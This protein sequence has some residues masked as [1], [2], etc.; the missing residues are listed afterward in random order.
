MDYESVVAASFQASP[1]DAVSA[2]TV[3]ASP[4]RRLRDAIEPIAMHSVW[5]RATN[6]R[7]AEMDLDFLT[8]YVWGRAAAL[9]EPDAGVVVA[10]F[11]VFEPGL[12]RDAYEQGRR[13]CPRDRLLAARTD[14]TVASLLETLEGADV[15]S[16]ADILERAVSVADGTGRPLFSGLAGQPWPADPVG[17]L[18][19][20]CE[21]VREHRGDSHVAA[22]IS[23]GL[24]P[25]DMNILTELWVGMPLGS[26]SGTRGW[27]HDTIRSAAATLERTGLLEGDRLSPAGQT[28]RDEL[29][30]ATDAMQQPVIE[31]LGADVESLIEQ[32]AAWSQRCIGAG[33]FPPD[34]FKRAAG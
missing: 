3:Q 32:L 2:P 30:A 25:V 33:A 4:A 19:R 5:S 26:Y 22:C 7:L 9:G 17:R 28:F 10:A 21:L 29:E 23:R 27:A 12:V 13:A 15:T 20:A 1:P 31:A 18:W 6:E 11:A 14:A 8:G 24:G 34:V 16:V